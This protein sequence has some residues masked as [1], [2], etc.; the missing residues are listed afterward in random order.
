MAREL[1]QAA[2]EKQ[3]QRQNDARTLA[4]AAEIKKDKIRMAGAVKESKVMVKNDIKRLSAMKS[5]A[6]IKPSFK[7]K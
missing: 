6:Q 3:W 4:D 2:Q 1:S 7:K 5:V